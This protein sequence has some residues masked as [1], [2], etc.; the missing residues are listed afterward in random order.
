MWA[1][2][3]IPA[4][5]PQEI[6]YNCSKRAHYAQWLSTFLKI[7]FIYRIALIFICETSFPLGLPFISQ[8]VTDGLRRRGSSK[9]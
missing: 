4:S 1:F 9:C 8:T 3:P 5:L 7:I 6:S 2:I